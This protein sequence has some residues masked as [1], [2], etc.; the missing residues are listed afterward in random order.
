MMKE[1]DP[2]RCGKSPRFWRFGDVYLCGC[3]NP[4]C[5]DVYPVRSLKSKE[6]AIEQ[7]NEKMKGERSGEQ[8]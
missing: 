8:R 2:C 1:I 3:I 4:N 7:W 6:D 5:T